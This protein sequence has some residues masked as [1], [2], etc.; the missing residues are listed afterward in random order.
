LPALVVAGEDE[1]RVACGDLLAAIHGL[2]S[3]KYERLRP[4]I[5]NLALTANVMLRLI[6]LLSTQAAHRTESSQ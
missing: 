5:A 6:T 4:Q 3:S 1:H 2:L